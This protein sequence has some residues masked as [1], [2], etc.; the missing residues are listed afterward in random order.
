MPV[1]NP[2]GSGAVHID[3]VLTQISL[4]WPNNGLVGEALFPSVGVR[5][6]SN[7]YYVFGHDGWLPEEDVRAPGSVANELP[8]LE[9]STEPYYAREHS[10]QIPVTD[11]E[12]DNADNPLSPDRDGTEMITS[13]IMLGREQDIKNLATNTNKYATN[14]S[15]TLSGT[16]QWNDHAN[17]SPIDDFKT[18]RDQVHSRIFMQPTLSI[19]PYQVMSELE[20]HPDII[21][22]VKYSERAVLTE[23]I[24]AQVFGVD[25]IIVPGVGVASGNP[26]NTMSIGYLWGKDVVMA[27]VPGRPGMRIPAYGYEFTWNYG[28]GQAQ[29][30]D[31]WREDPRKSDL[32]RVSRRYDLKHV[33]VATE[34][35]EGENGADVGKSIAGYVIKNAVA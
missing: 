28:A 5:K 3:E 6:Q 22:R 27:W 20:D 32:I 8:G 7:L 18:G 15:T 25:R 29:Q 14:N 34:E 9:V 35:T 16:A 13:K 30:V 33:G 1:Y 24:I 26:G 23:E 10:L 21:E 17:S 4:G 19:I 12:R 11:E 2:S 31:R